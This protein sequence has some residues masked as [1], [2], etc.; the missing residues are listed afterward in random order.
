[1]VDIFADIVQIVV[2]ATGANTLLSVHRS[3]QTAQIAVG[4]HSFLEDGFELVHAGIGEQQS[5]VIM[6]NLT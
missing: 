3:F 5:W 2:L 1:M 4:V 6:R